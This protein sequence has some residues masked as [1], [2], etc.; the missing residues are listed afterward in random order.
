MRL[1]RLRVGRKL[2]VVL[3]T[4]ATWVILHG[5]RGSGKSWVVARKLLIKGRKHKRTILCVREIQN[6]IVD[7]VHKL[8]ADE[9][10]RL[11]LGYFYTVM[12]NE[13]RGANG[14]RFIYAGIKTDPNKIKSVENVSDLWCEEAEN[15]SEESWRIVLPTVGRNAS[16][17]QIFVV[18]NPYSEGDPT[19]VRFLKAPPEGALV[20]ECNWW[21]NPDFP[22]FLRALKDDDY[23]RDPAAAK[24]TWEGKTIEEAGT[25]EF[26][27][28]KMKKCTWHAD[29]YQG[30]NWY[31]LVD[32]SGS[33]KKIQGDWTVMSPIGL[34]RDRFIYQGKWTR[35]KFNLLEKYNRMVE[36]HEQYR[37]KA[38]GYEDSS[39]GLE[40]DYFTQK[41]AETGY[42]LPII[43]LKATKA[44][45]D[46]IRWLV[47][48]VSEMRYLIPQESIYRQLDGVT[49][50]LTQQLLLEMRSFPHIPDTMHDD[51]LD[52]SSRIMDPDLG[53]YYPTAKPTTMVIPRQEGR[54]DPASGVRI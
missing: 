8:L 35:D 42:R 37:F 4:A 28:E 26:D 52:A 43:P 40:I 24:H 17:P 25:T 11:G 15:I 3:S 29:N 16:D 22:E 6:S 9:I 38:I 48:L 19:Y 18:F 44:K 41:G 53:A 13:I 36:L 20:I 49:L 45:E 10:E 23:R 30:K 21:D 32:P 12:A 27:M 31:L 7:S 5:G 2:A 46:R 14:T 51:M 47:P 50:D 39:G 33:K 34:G 1:T 54:Y